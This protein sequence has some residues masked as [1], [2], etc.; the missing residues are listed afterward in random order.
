[1]AP[2]GS[3]RWDELFS[4]GA[5]PDPGLA[6]DQDQVSAPI[7]GIVKGCFEFRPLVLPAH[8]HPLSQVDVPA[9]VAQVATLVLPEEHAVVVVLSNRV[10]EDIG[11]MAE[12]LV[13]AASPD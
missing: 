1:M 8:E 12:P 5:L 11:G 6:G 13:E 4:Q 2:K 9:S 3:A 10:V 7:E